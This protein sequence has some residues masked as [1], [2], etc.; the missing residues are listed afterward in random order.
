MRGAQRARSATREP[1]EVATRCYRVYRQHSYGSRERD[2]EDR[3]MWKREEERA[4]QS[5]S[6]SS[7]E[8]EKLKLIEIRYFEWRNVMIHTKKELHS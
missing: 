7:I 2:D 8:I 6:E 1:N 5:G 4:E 3:E